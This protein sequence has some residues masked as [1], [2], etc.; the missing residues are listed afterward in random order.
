MRNNLLQKDVAGDAL[1][2]LAGASRYVLN[3]LQAALNLAGTSPY[4]LNGALLA[5]RDLAALSSV[6]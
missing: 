2:D 3:A 4:I 1:R 5:A 6:N